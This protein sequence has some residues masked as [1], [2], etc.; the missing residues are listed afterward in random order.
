M[1]DKAWCQGARG[2]SL[3]LYIVKNMQ[4]VWHDFCGVNLPEKTELLSLSMDTQ[5]L[6]ISEM[7]SL[8]AASVALLLWKGM[9]VHGKPKGRNSFIEERR[10]SEM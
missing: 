6:G 5:Q 8:R 4:L 2:G 1:D 3:Q 9:Q 7:T 10:V